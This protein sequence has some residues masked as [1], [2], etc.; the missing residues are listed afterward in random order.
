MTARWF[1]IP[2]LR[3]YLPTYLPTSKYYI[4]FLVPSLFG[5][6][7]WRGQHTF[8]K[9]GSSGARAVSTTVTWAPVCCSTIQV[10]LHVR[11]EREGKKKEPKL[12]LPNYYS[13]DRQWARPIFPSYAE[14]GIQVVYFYAHKM[15]NGLFAH[16][17]GELVYLYLDDWLFF[18]NL[19]PQTRLGRT[20][21][22]T[23]F[24]F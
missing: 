17:C 7:R 6:F 2:T 4:N 18:N 21:M 19:V 20:C 5:R 15:I 3:R 12:R 1:R 16:P 11:V 10:Y 8:S 24:A 14:Y 9:R 13:Q 23:F 22:H